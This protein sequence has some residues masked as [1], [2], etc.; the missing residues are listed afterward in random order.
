MPEETVR[1]LVRCR[2]FNK[3][4]KDLNCQGVIEMSPEVLTLSEFLWFDGR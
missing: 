3:R 4:E 1:V 2:P